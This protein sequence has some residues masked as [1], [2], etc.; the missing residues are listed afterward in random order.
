MQDGSSSTR[1]LAEVI[2]HGESSQA[3]YNRKIAATAECAAT[4][5]WAAQLL[6]WLV[7]HGSPGAAREEAIALRAP[8]EELAARY[9]APANTGK[10]QSV[11]SA[12]PPS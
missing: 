7:E 9:P 4:F 6:G 3:P 10:T 11:K 5:L 1:P 8:F 2:G 12:T